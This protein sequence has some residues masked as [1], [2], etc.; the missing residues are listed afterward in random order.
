[1]FSSST[2]GGKA[3]LQPTG[4]DLCNFALDR[5]HRLART[6]CGYGRAACERTQLFHLMGELKL[7]GMEAAFDEIMAS[8]STSPNAS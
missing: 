5:G 6:A 2:S 1:M 7:Y 4:L 8:A 3:G